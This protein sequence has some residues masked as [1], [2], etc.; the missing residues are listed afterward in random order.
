MLDVNKYI[1][2]YIYL[3]DRGDRLGSNLISL[4]AQVCYAHKYNCY[5]KYQNNDKNS[6]KYKDSIFYMTI[7]DFI[8]NFNIKLKHDSP[9][10]EFSEHVNIEF[11]I[12]EGHELQRLTSWVTHTIKS[13]LITYFRDNIYNH[14]NFM[15]IASEKNYT[16]PF[17]P[18]T[19]VLVHLR[20]DD[21]VH[22]PDYDGTVCSRHYQELMNSN[23]L[24][25]F[26]IH[27]PFNRQAPLSK[28]KVENILSYNIRPK[29]PEY[30][31]II[32]TSPISNT[33]NYPYTA[34]KSDDASYDMFLL[35]MTNVVLLSRS[36][37]SIASLAFGPKKDD[38]NIPSWGHMISD[39]LN[40]K[41][42]KTNFSYFY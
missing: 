21:T 29:Y 5:I 17:D 11:A 30:Q 35:S 31:T 26:G 19:T 18:N 40:T 12:Q 20:L 16:I 22:L 41:Y 36:N 14:E 6:H 42:D 27:W 25:S 4:I 1:C 15:R 2:M 8:D 38:V 33:A 10:I 7:F 13:D 3:F 34:I 28:E 39:G 24:C 9:D 32:L 37:F 23:R